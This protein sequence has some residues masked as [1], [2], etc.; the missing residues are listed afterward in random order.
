MFIR[1]YTTLCLVLSYIIITLTSTVVVRTPY[2]H[3]VVASS[4][5]PTKDKQMYDKPDCTLKGHYKASLSTIN[6]EARST[7]MHDNSSL[8]M[9]E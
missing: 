7:T 2:D 3:M 1:S 8:V 9:R 4:P 6:L 5:A